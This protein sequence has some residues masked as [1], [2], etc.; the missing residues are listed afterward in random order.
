VKGRPL[1]RHVLRECFAVGLCLVF[2]CVFDDESNLLKVRGF[3]QSSEPIARLF[4]SL[5]TFD[6]PVSLFVPS[7]Q[8][9]V[10]S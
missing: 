3:V 7:F 5:A 10:S 4:A 8:K 6:D 2:D 9:Y 1:R